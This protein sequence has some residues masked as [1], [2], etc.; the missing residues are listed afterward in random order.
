VSSI[1]IEESGSPYTHPRFG[2]PNGSIATPNAGIIT[3]TTIGGRTV[4]IG[5][6]LSF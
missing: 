6:R 4:Q 1:F 3:S 5:A 2:N